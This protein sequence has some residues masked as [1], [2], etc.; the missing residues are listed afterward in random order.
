MR[1][2]TTKKFDKQFRKQPVRVKKEFEKRVEIFL[3]DVNDPQLHVHKLKG[4]YDKL[5]SLN[6]KGDVR[7]IFDKRQEPLI[8]FIEIGSHSE[9]YS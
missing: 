3:A 8:I 7:V 1:I 6:V 9:L 5:W 2:T 4:V